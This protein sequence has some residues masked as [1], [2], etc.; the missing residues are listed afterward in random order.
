LSFFPFPPLLRGPGTGVPLFSLFDGKIGRVHL[1]GVVSLGD[2]FSWA[3]GRLFCVQENCVLGFPF[4]QGGWV[5]L[6]GRRVSFLHLSKPPLPPQVGSKHTIDDPPATF[7]LSRISFF[8]P[9]PMPRGKL[10]HSPETQQ[11]PNEMSSGPEASRS[12]PARIS[13]FLDGSF[14][15]QAEDAMMCDGR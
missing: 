2:F 8:S 6:L 1:P 10:G 3:S 7:F 9:W 12:I 15:A 5:M 11:Q 13:F 4:L 14:S